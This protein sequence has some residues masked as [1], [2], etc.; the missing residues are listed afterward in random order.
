VDQVNHHVD[1]DAEDNRHPHEVDHRD[2]DPGHH[3]QRN[4]PGDAGQQ[5]AHGA[6]NRAQPPQVQGGE[7][8]HQA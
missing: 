7:E 4:P 8:Q 6:R 1:T 5:H 3:H 2:L